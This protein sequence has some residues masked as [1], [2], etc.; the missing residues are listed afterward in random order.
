MWPPDQ[1]LTSSP[2][3]SSLRL[4]TWDYG[5]RAEFVRHLNTPAVL[6]WLGG[7]QDEA[8]YT[9]AFERID[10]YQRDFGHTLWIVE[11]KWMMSCLVFA[12]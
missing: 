6:R 12:G 7:V 8:E 1:W 9:A 5:D 3:L 2:R 10:S 4:R 11:R